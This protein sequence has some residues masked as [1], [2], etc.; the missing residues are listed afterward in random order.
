LRVLAGAPQFTVEG[1]QDGV[2]RVLDDARR[3]HGLT[4]VDAGTLARKADQTVLKSATHV[5]WVMLA[6]HAGIEQARR[7]LERI[8]PLG[9]PELLVARTD[10]SEKSPVSRLA[11]L[12]DERRARLVL[13]P[14]FGSPAIG[15]QTPALVDRA[16]V[17]LQAI[18]GAL[19][20]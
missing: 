12:A 8:A 16:Q 19:H 13:M 6:N 5:A 3:A 20:S 2:G 14:S 18:G 10:P 1:D 4:V 9:R 11:D 15:E 17:A 7:V